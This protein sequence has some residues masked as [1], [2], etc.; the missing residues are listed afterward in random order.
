MTEK[1]K[2]QQQTDFEKSMSQYEQAMRIFHKGDFGKAE[3]LLAAFVANE[4]HER[5]LFDRAQIYLVI[6]RGKK[7]KTSLLLKTFD[8][9]FN[10]GVYNIN[11]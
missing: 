9:Y 5:E 2:K 3:E 8:D 1:K 6:C 10:A 7:D 4:S 11:S